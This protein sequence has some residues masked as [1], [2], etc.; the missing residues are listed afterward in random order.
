MNI[1]DVVILVAED[2]RDQV[3]L[4]QRAFRKANLVNPPVVV[5]DGEETIRYLEG[6]EEFGDR[7]R[8]PLP[9]LLLLDLKMPKKTGLEV[10]DWVRGDRR[11]R[12]LPVVILTSSVDE[13]DI[14]KAYALGVN[15]YMVKPVHFP[16][17]VDLMKSI[18]NRW[19]R[20]PAAPPSHDPGS[21]SPK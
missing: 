17:L 12:S 6:R 18:L 14:Q 4:I 19:Q 8:H 21:A 16:D 1:A 11:F 10:L 13:V 20:F 7:R 9:T 5:R 2:D 3:L 15:S